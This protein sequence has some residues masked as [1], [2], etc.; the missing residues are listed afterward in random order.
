[1]EGR[2]GEELNTQAAVVAAGETGFAGMADD[3]RF[4]GDAVSG[5]EMRDGGMD[6]DDDSCRLV[7]EDVGVFYDHG[8]NPSGMPEVDIRPVNCVC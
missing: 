5:F 6:G 2:R 7:P 3:I 4:D 8:P 1:M